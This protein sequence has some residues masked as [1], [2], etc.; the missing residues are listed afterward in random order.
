MIHF[1]DARSPWQNGRTE[2]AGGVFKDKLE[3]TIKE[4]CAT[5][6]DEIAM[7]LRRPRSPGIDTTTELASLRINERLELIPGCRTLCLAMTISIR[8]SSVLGLQQKFNVHGRS[9]M[10]LQ[11]RG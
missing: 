3:L 11:P 10:P 9:V 4:T 7:A 8:S 6:P 2:R 1:I 5:T